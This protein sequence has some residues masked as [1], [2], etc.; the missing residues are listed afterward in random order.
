MDDFTK[1]LEQDFLEEAFSLIDNLESSLLQLEHNPGDTKSINEVFRVAHTIKGGAGTVG[2][3]EI[4]EFTH[5]IE[6]ILD[7]VRKNKLALTTET[8]TVLLECR[9]IIER[10]LN[11][12]TTG[13]IYEDPRTY[14]I[15]DILSKLKFSSADAAK[16]DAKSTAPVAPQS[17]MSGD[18]NI[19]L[20][21]DDFTMINDALSK[22]RNVYLMKFLL[23]ESYEMKE[24]SSFQLYSLLNDSA[25]IIKIIP[26]LDELEIKFYSEVIFIIASDR[27][28]NYLKD[29][30]FLH[31]MVVQINSIKIDSKKL[32]ELESSS[33]SQSDSHPQETTAAEE[34]PVTGEAS[35][36]DE[37]PQE[38]EQKDDTSV[39]KRN[40][41]TLR[42][43]SW[44]VDN[45]LNLLGELVITK[46]T[47]TQLDNDFDRISTDVKSSLKEFLNGIMRLNLSGE[48][49]IVSEKNKSLL[50]ALTLMFSSFDVF[51]ENIQKINR[52]SSSL[53][54][55]VMNMRMVPIQTV[56]TRFPRLIR[57]IASKLDKKIDLIIEGV[58][59]EIDK[60]MVDDIFDPL[61]HL[62]RNA[63][64]HGIELPAKRKAA[65]KPEIGKIIL[66]AT[67]EG[68]SIVIEVSD[69]GNGID[70]EVLR[71][72]AIAANTM[73]RNLL[74]KMSHRE[75]LG[76]IFLPGFSTA[77]EVSNLSGRG[78]GMDIV[79][80]KIEEIG[81]N[82]GISTVKGKGTKFIIR[83]PLTLA[84]IQ[85][86]LIVVE[87]MYYVIP[88]ASV[89]ETVI[90][91]PKN[92]KDING[93]FALELR[94]KLIPILALKN[95]FYGLPFNIQDNTKEYCIVTKY[96]E[97]QVGIIVSEVIGEQDIVIKP[98]NTK[99]I[100]SP[101]ISAATIVGNG[102]IGYIIDT[103]QIISYFFKVGMKT[104][105]EG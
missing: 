84:I 95:F 27:D 82:V 16:P 36:S 45:L 103:S 31:E 61:I 4:Q 20:S 12:R 86:L 68:D 7:M 54:E 24:V 2:F 58:E 102:D 34:M 9:D 50:N 65:N 94:D 81:G 66:K 39:E 17:Q 25:E 26:S 56:F 1:E 30:T 15:I 47:F 5:L 104:Q 60:G 33:A 99:L 14:Q 90:I 22:G 83:L 51:S 87:G 6:D 69:D 88:V 63:V 46:S 85:G 21:N 98:L 29:K 13:A 62:L 23:N 76:L 77:K 75:L 70:P 37:A 105:Q 10:M 53:Q 18:G 57:D 92:L 32:A 43:E 52:I 55:N 64:D 78:V 100:K 35:P 48:P 8:I 97:R 74:Q 73:D 11:A 71:A 3:D 28:E 93:T 96:G 80:K 40:L 101:G 79:R 91:D 42:V 72:K 38:P 89:E 59:T 44:K 19:P 49:D 41:S 67:H